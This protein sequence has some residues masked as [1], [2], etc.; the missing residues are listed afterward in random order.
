L[1]S[2]LGWTEPAP[3]LTGVEGIAFRDIPRFGVAVL[4]E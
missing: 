4:S 3:K 1:S 2:C